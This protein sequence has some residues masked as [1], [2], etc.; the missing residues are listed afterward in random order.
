MIEGIGI[1][2]VDIPRFKRSLDE[3]GVH[4]LERIFTSRE[5][6]YSSSK[7]YQAQHFAARF[8]VKEAVVKAIASGAVKGFRWKDIEVR[9]DDIGKPHV[10]LHG[11]L[12]EILKKKHIHVSISHSQETVVAVAVIEM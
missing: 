8:A 12:A 11:Q 1:D 10:A 6:E 5:I 3:W 9:N 2:I 7:F 4:F